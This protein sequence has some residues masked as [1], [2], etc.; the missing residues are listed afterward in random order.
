[1]TT[2]GLIFPPDRPPEELREVAL[3][4]DESGVADLWLWEDCFAESGIATAAAVLAWTPRLRVGI[5]LLPVPLRNVALTAMELATLARLFPGRLRPGI[6]HGV[7]DW[8]GQVGARAQS[9]M[10]LL[11]EY[12]VALRDLL[13]GKTV[14][15][16]GRYVQL[17]DVTLT[18]PPENVPPVLIGA[19]GPKTLEVAGRLGDGVILTGETT[20]DEVRAAVPAVRAAQQADDAAPE[21]VVFLPVPGRPSAAELAARIAEYADAG[22]TTL[23]LLSVGD[24]APPLAE[25]ARFV[26]RDVSPLVR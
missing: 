14:S 20:L 12:A 21:V 19:V 23:A 10:T 24:T 7:L 4:A 18:W 13:H 11:Q 9:P 5:G 25:F 2:L 1:M 16:S 15:T 8:M 26:G 22:A 6:G 3:A 17:A